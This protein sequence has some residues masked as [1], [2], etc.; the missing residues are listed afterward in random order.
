MSEMFDTVSTFVFDLDGTI[1]EGDN[2]LPGSKE[3]IEYLQD[4]GYNILFCTNNSSKTR[5]E[6]AT[7]LSRMDIRCDE[8]NIFSSGWATSQYVNS[9]G[10]SNIW[11][12]GSDSLMKMM[13][14]F[15]L[16]DSPEESNCLIVGFDSN[17]DYQRLTYA[18]RACDYCDYVI[19]C[20]ED[21]QYR[22]DGGKK[23]P[24]CGGMTYA[25]REC[26]GREPNVIIGKPNQYMMSL[27]MNKMSLNKNEIIVIGDSYES[28][29]RFAE[30]TGT[31][32][33][34]ISDEDRSDVKCMKTL[35][36]L[37]NF[38]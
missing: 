17:F 9:I 26:S 13:S 23:F 24:G 22:G 28:D 1:Y 35:C 4:L 18:I 12:V 33:I 7:K 16:A 32:S 21:R 37:R 19:Y 5:L 6:L 11:V 25:I 38:F 15:G 36:D 27:I 30:N 14:K 31:F 10:I 8:E 34:L 20:N 2:L 3:A 29:I